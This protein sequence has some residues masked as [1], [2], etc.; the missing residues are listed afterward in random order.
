MTTPCQSKPVTVM[1]DEERTVTF[2]NR[3][4]FRM[5]SLD[6]P[7]SIQDLRNK[8]RSW[9]ALV[10]WIWACLSEHDAADFPSPESLAVHLQTKEAIGKAFEAFVDTYTAAQAPE[11][12]NAEG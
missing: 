6:R 4:E 7:F 9:A 10:A 11:S 8:R 2:D 3:A 12:K 1:L 5:G